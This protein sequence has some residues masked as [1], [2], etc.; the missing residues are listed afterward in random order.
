[1]KT[2]AGRFLR[3]S[4]APAGGLFPVAQLP[5]GRRSAQKTQQLRLGKDHNETSAGRLRFKCDGTRAETRYL[6]SAKR[7]SLFKPAGASVQ[8]TTGSRSVRISGSNAGYTTF[9][10]SV[11]S[12]G[13]ALHSPVSPSL[14]LRASPCAITFQLDSTI[15]S[16]SNKT[17]NQNRGTA[18]VQTG[19]A[20][21]AL[22]YPQEP[23]W[24]FA[25]EGFYTV[26]FIILTVLSVY[27]TLL[28][29]Y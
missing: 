17:L 29:G 6:L 11:K 10:G 8:S 26:T 19:R 14:P 20:R 16:V 18:A 1:M 4:C 7:T 15:A 28:S 2:G 24:T 9:R 27:F 23:F 22:I 13:Y 12:T 5:H 25:K 3:Y 21:Y